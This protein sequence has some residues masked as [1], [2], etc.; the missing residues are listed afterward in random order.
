MNIAQTLQ[1]YNETVS[2]IEDIAACQCFFGDL[3][4]LTV[5]RRHADDYGLA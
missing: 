2:P 1:G 5:P 4:I 3:S